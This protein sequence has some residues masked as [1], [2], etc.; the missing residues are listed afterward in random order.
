M[1]SSSR[2]RGDARRK[3]MLVNNKYPTTRTPTYF[4]SQPLDARPTPT[5]IG[6]RHKP[7]LHAKTVKT[8]GPLPDFLR[9]KDEKM[10]YDELNPFR[11]IESNGFKPSKR[12]PRSS[13]PEIT[14]RPASPRSSSHSKESTFTMSSNTSKYSSG[15]KVDGKHSHSSRTQRKESLQCEDVELSLEQSSS[16]GL[17]NM[18]IISTYRPPDGVP[19]STEQA[20]VRPWCIVD[21]SGFKL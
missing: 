17:R 4:I 18:P 20:Q 11:S 6:A 16:G 2:L 5:G 13:T 8:E 9:D 7:R 19:I 15:S 10:E 1:S 3:G 14:L 21:F 12:K